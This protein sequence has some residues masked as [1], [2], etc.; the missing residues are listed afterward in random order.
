MD[1]TIDTVK[2]AGNRD[3]N[4]PSLPGSA[5]VRLRQPLEYLRGI[6]RVGNQIEYATEKFDSPLIVSQGHVCLCPGENHEPS[7]VI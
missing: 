5:L 6:E 7:T 2:G 3:E 4:E 1:V